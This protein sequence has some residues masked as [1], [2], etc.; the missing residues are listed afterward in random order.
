LEYVAEVASVSKISADEENLFSIVFKNLA[1][2]F[3]RIQ[4]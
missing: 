3:V 4:E 1:A 2:F